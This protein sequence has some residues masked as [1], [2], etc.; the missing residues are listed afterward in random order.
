M[1]K[2]KNCKDYHQIGYEYKGRCYNSDFRNNVR[3]TIRLEDEN[4]EKR[5][6]VIPVI[7]LNF[8][9]KEDFGC[10]YFNKKEKNVNLHTVD[11][12]EL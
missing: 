10:K 7:D 6:I 12:G 4:G 8:T 11:R 3:L 5:N 1:A 2:C 9:V